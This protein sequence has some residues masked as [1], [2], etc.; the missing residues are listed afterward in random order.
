MHIGI[1]QTH[2]SNAVLENFQFH[3]ALQYDL[4]VHLFKTR[5]FLRL[6]PLHIMLLVGEI[7]VKDS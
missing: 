1:E 4:D 2:N 7:R 3:I 6:F 5:R